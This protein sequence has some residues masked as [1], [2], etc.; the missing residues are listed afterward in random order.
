MQCARPLDGVSD[1]TACGNVVLFYQ[2]R[3]EE[4][5]AMIIAAAR[6]HRVFLRASKPWDGLARV[7]NFK[8][9]VLGQKRKF[10]GLGRR[11]A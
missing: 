2:K 8:R 5:Q 1:A 9:R 6:F 10:T 7:Q 11:A 3:I 4:T